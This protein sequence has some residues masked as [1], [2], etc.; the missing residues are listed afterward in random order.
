[1]KTIK[2]LSLAAVALFATASLLSAA[3]NHEKAFATQDKDGDGAISLEE[4]TNARIAWAMSQGKKKGLSEAQ[5]EENTA[6]ASKSSKQRFKKFDKDKD[7]ILSKEE[8][9][10]MRKKG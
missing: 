4:L 9:L 8:W 1:M 7:G 5:I 6:K 10:K 3:P 2:T